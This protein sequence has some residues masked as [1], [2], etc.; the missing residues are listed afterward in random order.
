MLYRRE[1]NGCNSCSSIKKGFDI[2]GNDR[3]ACK[4]VYI[5]FVIVFLEVYE[6]KMN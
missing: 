2:V 5:V 1:K 4:I 3:V 6:K